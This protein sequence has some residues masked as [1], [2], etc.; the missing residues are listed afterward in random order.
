MSITT[1]NEARISA[2]A[3]ELANGKTRADIL[4]KYGESWQISP[5]SLDRV[6]AQ[7]KKKAAT[8]IETAEK[9]IQEETIE[10]IKEAAVNGLRSALEVDLEI[11]NII[12]NKHILV[13][14]PDKTDTNGRVIE[15]G[16]VVK[17]D[18]TTADRLKAAQL[19]YRRHNLLGKEDLTKKKL[20]VKINGKPIPKPGD[21]GAAGA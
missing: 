10:V 12:F 18:N 7:A 19:Y 21:N 17:V 6:I 16:R 20:I 9:K 11:Q 13:R 2:V 8:I 15:K 14:T 4:A 1:G 5:R 3:I